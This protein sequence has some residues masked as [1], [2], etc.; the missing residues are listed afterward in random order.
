MARRL[1]EPDE[2]EPDPGSGPRPVVVPR[3]R[4]LKPVAEPTVRKA[5]ARWLK[6]RGNRLKPGDVPQLPRPKRLRIDFRRYTSPPR[7]EFETFY[8]SP[9]KVFLRLMVWLSTA[10]RFLFGT[11][12]DWIV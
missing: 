1:N 11:A 10:L 2:D 5:L 6:V 12:W 7:R 9:V 8:A 3:R 4:T